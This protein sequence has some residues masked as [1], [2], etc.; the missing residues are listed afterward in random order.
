MLN[1]A[2]NWQ[3]LSML[4]SQPYFDTLTKTVSI[5]DQPFL[6]TMSLGFSSGTL[7]K[8]F[9][10]KKELHRVVKAQLSRVASRKILISVSIVV[11]SLQGVLSSRY[12]AGAIYTVQRGALVRRD[13]K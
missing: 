4:I 2:R 13:P 12:T 5:C 8:S 9:S 1:I 11:V 3:R 10:N 6:Y 7:I